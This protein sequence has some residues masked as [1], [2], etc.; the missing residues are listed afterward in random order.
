M[1]EQNRKIKHEVRL[2]VSLIVSCWLL[3]T[4][5]L[6]T[7]LD[8]YSVISGVSGKREAR[9]S[10]DWLRKLGIASNR[11]RARNLGI[12]QR[13]IQIFCTDINEM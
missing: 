3:C 1:Q 10:I 9:A 8:S 2:M 13:P 11:A 7:R 5:K 4:L 12:Q 6:E